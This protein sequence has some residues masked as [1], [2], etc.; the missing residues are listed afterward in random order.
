M[1]YQS[2]LSKDFGVQPIKSMK[3]LF[4]LLLAI[5]FS[6]VMVGQAVLAQEG[7]TTATSTPSVLPLDKLK[8]VGAGAGY[9]SS[10]TET[11]VL[12]IVGTAINVALG[13]LGIIFIILIL[14]AGFNW[15]T[16]AG[17]E[18][19]IKKAGATIRAAIIGLLIVI[20]SFGIWLFISR[21]LIGAP[22]V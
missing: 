17:D 8:T 11:T 20:G 7:S 22:S 6:S 5:L 4:L 1:P 3:K 9:D 10:S 13:L 21:V 19:K 15:M 16:A 14:I 2:L 12:G 18:E